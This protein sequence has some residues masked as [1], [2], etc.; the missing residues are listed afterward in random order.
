MKT[1]YDGYYLS[2]GGSLFNPRSVSKTLMRGVCVLP[3]LVLRWT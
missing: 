3:A 1:W 2:D